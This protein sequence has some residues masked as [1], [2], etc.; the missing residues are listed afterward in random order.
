MKQNKILIYLMAFA[1][2]ITISAFSVNAA[3]SVVDLG[4]AGDFAIL[5]KAGISTTG[6]TLITGNIGVSPIDHT[7]ITGFDLIG[8]PANDL[9]LTSTLVTGNIYAAN[10]VPPTPSNMGTAISN[11]ETAFTD[12]QGRTTDS[13]PEDTTELGAG[14]ISGMTIVP[15]LHKWSSGLLINAGGSGD[16]DG[17]TLDCQGDAD[18]VFI[19]QIA[20]DLTFG[21]GAQVTLIDGCQSNNIFWAVSG[22]SGVIID[23]TAH[24]EGNLLAST[25]ISLNTGATVNGRLLA[26]TAVTLDAN[27]ITVS[28]LEESVLTEITLT[29]LTATMIVGETEQLTATGFDQ[30]DEIFDATINYT[31]NDTDVA[32][33]SSLGLV[34][35][36]SAGSATIIAS[37][38]TVSSLASVITVETAAPILDTIGSRSIT[39]GTELNFTITATSQEGLDLVFSIDGKPTTADF[40]DNTNGTAMFSWTPELSDVGITNITFT[41]SD[42]IKSDSEVVVITINE[43]QAPTTTS[44]NGDTWKNVDYN[45]TLNATGFNDTPI[46]YINYS[47]NDVL[48]QIDGSVGDILIDINGNN[49]LTFYAVDTLGNVETPTTIYAMLDKIDPNITSFILSATSVNTGDVITGTCIVTDNLYTDIIGVITGIDTTTAGTKT[50]TCTATDLADNVVTSSVTYTVNTVSSSSGGGHS[51]GSSSGSSGGYCTTEWSCT[52][53][54]ACDN[55]LQTRTCSYTAHSCT[56]IAT[57]PELTQSCTTISTTDS[58]N[59]EQDTET[60]NQDYYEL[61]IISDDSDKDSVGFGQI[62]GMATG[63]FGSVGTGISHWW[64]QFINWIV[65]LFS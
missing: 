22:G 42:G 26:Q 43:F 18:A 25:A 45:V 21:P 13:S 4:T 37:S 41:V 3:Q 56:P 32:T 15:G 61:D 64:N 65:N 12:A 30:Y 29:P 47:L 8:V 60:A 33:V 20:Q 24:V 9:F 48:G 36:V 52:E 50:A 28:E 19:F 17:V 40:T 39:Q 49:T 2:I 16:P 5:S 51:G 44:T 11:M 62:T 53:W 54:N 35:A 7:A 23:T 31:S 10:L 55:S 1:I 57:S 59:T 63:I 58:N 14:D 46:A 34:T 6:V 27:T 38:D